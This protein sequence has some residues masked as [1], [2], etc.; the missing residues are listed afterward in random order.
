MQ[1]MGQ[2]VDVPL[3]ITTSDY[4]LE[5]VHDFAYLGSTILDS[6]TIDMELNK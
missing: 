4:K 6:I 5:V 3:S 1:V 2:D